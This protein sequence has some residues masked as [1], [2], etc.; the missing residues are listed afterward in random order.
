MSYD[1]FCYKSNLGRPD[2]DEASKIIE[3]DNDIW[4][5][6]PYNYETKTAIE[7]ALLD[8]DSKLKGFNYD[9]L[10]RKKN[11]LVTD[12][13]REFQKFELNSA[14]NEPEIHI[15]IFDYHVTLT[16]PYL[17][18]DAVAKS[19]F[20]RLK[21][22]IKIINDTV[23]YFVYDPQTGEAFNPINNKFDGLRKYLSVSENIDD[24][25]KPVEQI[26]SKKPWWKF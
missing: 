24:I 10:S 13:K 1:I 12:V 18:Q 25:F 16:I 6:K 3:D 4:V 23:G 17:Y 7:K 8:F 21:S 14:E 22:Y 15:E 2:I 11:K 20:E 19:V 5:K 9:D 26:K